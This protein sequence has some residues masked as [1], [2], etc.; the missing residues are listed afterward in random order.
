MP[1]GGPPDVAPPFVVS[2]SPL[3][4][5]TDPKVKNLEIKFSEVISET[6]KGAAELR[7]LVF[8]SPRTGEEQVG[9]H[10]DR[11]TIQPKGGFKSNTVYSVQLS[12]GIQ[13]V[14]NNA[15]DTAI[16]VVFSTGGPIPTTSVTGVAFDW[17]L[18]RG[19]N[20]ALVEAIAKDSTTYQVLADTAGR[21]NLQY[22]PIGEYVI[23]AIVDRNANRLLDPTEAFDTVRITLTERADVE[24]YAFPRD[25]VGLRIADIQL[26]S[27]DSLKVMRVTFDKPLSPAQ[28]L[29][30]P[31]FV[32][33]DGDS[34]RIEVVFIQTALE[35]ITA[36]S[37]AQKTKQDSIAAAG[38]RDTTA[39]GRA[40]ADSLTRRIRSDSIAAA[41]R[42]QRE[43]RRLAARRGDRPPPPP[44][45]MPQPKMKRPVVSPEVYLTLA[46]RL[47]PG[48][49]YRIRASG[50]ISLSGTAKSPERTF[51]TPRE[52][53]R[54]TTDSASRRP[55]P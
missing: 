37:L 28:S 23:R 34:A 46:T 9:W 1:P 26:P 5:T 14:R 48:T 40:R 12:P 18:G 15:I 29:S 33:L 4:M 31:Q 7:Q 35:K 13:D 27:V 45:T 20:K 47:K 38:P 11:I 19:A 16:G 25:T 22:A 3:S 24:L 54:D 43:A 8:I 55:P 6:P 10:R 30:R 41:E 50:V 53:K 2:I 39:A 52:V 51:L 32:V 17:V 42:V 36:D 44:D 21:F 49:S